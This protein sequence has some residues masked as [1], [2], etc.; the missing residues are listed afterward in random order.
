MY[1]VPTLGKILYMIQNG[2]NYGPCF[3]AAN[4]L[5]VRSIIYNVY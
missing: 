1:K 4:S 3:Q 2:T 5:E